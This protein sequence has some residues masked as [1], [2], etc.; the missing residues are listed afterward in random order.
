MA[1]GWPQLMKVCRVRGFAL[2]YLEQPTGTY[3]MDPS[4]S[5]TAT[6]PSLLKH[7]LDPKSLCRRE[8]DATGRECFQLFSQA[9]GHPKAT[10]QELAQ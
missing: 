9:Q 8:V 4:I 7:R 2:R 3:N 10:Q 5:S 1:W 6:D